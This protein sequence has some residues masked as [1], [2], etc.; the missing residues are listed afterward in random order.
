M[1][2]K[3]LQDHVARTPRVES[4]DHERQEIS[5]KTAQRVAHLV[6]HLPPIYLLLL[7]LF[8][9]FILSLLIHLLVIAGTR[10]ITWEFA[11]AA[12]VKEHVPATIL[13]QGLSDTRLTFMGRDMQESFKVRESMVYPLPEIEYRPVTPDVRYFLDPGV[14]EPLD[15]ISIDAQ[16]LDSAWANP[17]TGRQPL[18]TGEE[19]L[20]ASFSK[21]IQ[22]LREGGL[23]V[24]F[25]FDSTGSMAEFIE[26]VKLKIAA[27][28]ATFKELVPA[29]RI[30]LVTYRDRGDAYVTRHHLLTH[31]VVSL[32]SFLK[33]I[34]SGGGGDLE[35]AIGEALRLTIQEFN[36]NPSSKKIILLIGDA[37]PHGDDLDQLRDLVGE[38]RSRMGGTVNALD[39]R[40]AYFKPAPGYEARAVLQVLEQFEYLA[41]IGGGE[42]ARMLDMERVV[43]QMVMM[44]FG[45][46]WEHVMDEFLKHL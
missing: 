34:D 8:S 12:P 24:V 31:G 30:G 42:S 21:H 22:S 27:M 3:R 29:A 16:A 39:T 46:R 5:M 15:L 41:H 1:R 23:D 14:N 40:R 10:Y 7:V 32:Q 43:R 35:E 28:A 13:L 17:S 2:S 33:D 11:A 26:R 4:A 20:A 38:F 18:Y 37:P 36:W 19:S 45:T 9:P 6:K 25:V 44:V